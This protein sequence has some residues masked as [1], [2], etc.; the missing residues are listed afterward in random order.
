MKPP[1]VRALNN[2]F[3]PDIWNSGRVQACA[4]L[5]NGVWIKI[6]TAYGHA[7]DPYNVDTME[8]TDQILQELTDRIIHQS[9]GP[10]VICGDFNHAKWSLGQ[11][12]IWQQHG[13]VE[14]Q[15]FAKEK[16]NREVQPTSRRE[17]VIDHVWVSPELIPLLR[18]VHTDDTLFPD[19]SVVYGV[20][21]L[22]KPPTSIPIWRKPLPIEWSEIGDLP[23]TPLDTEIV[24]TDIPGIF[25]ALESVVDRH[26]QMQDKPGKLWYFDDL[27]FEFPCVCVCVFDKN[28]AHG[29]THPSDEI[30]KND[31]PGR[32][33]SIF[34]SP[35]SL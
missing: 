1:P 35:K 23:D 27:F 9:C 7:V 16:W 17:T 24:P 12:S 20:F 14:L 33:P 30:D 34:R 32:N 31:Q 6:G 28:W 25:A 4:T 15:Q 2:S 19:H 18:E 3:D 10:R 8:R 21:D 26:L 5:V 13:F 29:E 22:P 11:F